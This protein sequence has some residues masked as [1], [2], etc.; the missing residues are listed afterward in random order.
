MASNVALAVDIIA[1]DKASKTLDTVGDK[2]EGSGKKF[3]KFGKAAVVGAGVAGVALLKFGKDSVAAYKESEQSQALLESAFKR[4]PATADISINA[5]RDY[6]AELAKKVTYDDDAIASGQATLAQFG[7]T[8]QQIKSITPYLADY[9]AK[10]GQDLPSAATALGKA[11]M[12]Q[13]RAL[14]GI[15]ADFK[16][17]G[18][19]SQN[20][21][22]LQDILK[23]KVGGTAE[24]MG[25]TAAGQA[26]ILSNQFGELQET[27]GAKLL[28]AIVAV[29]SAGLA[30]VNWISENQKIVVPLVAVIGA[31]ALGV[32]AVNAA[33][34]A[35]A[36][37]QAALNIVMSANPIALV[38]LAIAGLVAGIVIAYKKSETFRN[39]VNG[40]WGAL[41][42]AFTWVKNNWP[43]LLAILTG[44]FGLAV[45]AIVKYRDQIWNAI[46]ALPG[47]I[48]S[49]T[50]GM[51]DG[52]KDSF[53]SAI[54]WI[55]S[56]WNNLEFKIGGK[57]VF[58]QE[59]PGVTIG[60]PNLPMLAEGGIIRARPGGTMFVGGEGGRDELVAPLSRDGAISLKRSDLDYLADRLI[61]G[62]NGT[63]RSAITTA[64]ARAAH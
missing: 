47:L 25:S 23:A 17:T 33:A 38:V 48:K 36:A 15:G 20:L 51:W 11:V 55:I 53:K 43:L 58:G 46:K 52:I 37:T 4:F 13:G 31:L 42:T 30:M 28:P 63:S 21:A 49:A 14:K 7:L 40:V 16:D 6:N 32:W 1:R 59:L 44:P 34:K 22:Q 18:D 2:A 19:K 29:T 64:R 27:A 5:L 61:A 35:Y 9:A 56:K 41:K 62:I 50:S 24:A 45:A 12:G 39:A 57:K 3:G 10:T 26:E 8:G 54:N 60:T